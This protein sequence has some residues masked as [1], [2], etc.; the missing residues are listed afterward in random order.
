LRSIFTSI[1][2]GESN[3]ENYFTIRSLPE[4]KIEED[5]DNV[6]FDDAKTKTKNRKAKS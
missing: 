6:V 4:K 2:D 1:K 3:R 5:D